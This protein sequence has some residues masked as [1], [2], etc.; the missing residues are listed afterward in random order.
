L[1]RPIQATLV[2]KLKAARDRK[3]RQEGHRIEGRKGYSTTNP[4]LVH[5]AKRLA[6]RS[7]KTGKARPLREI[8]AE[9]AAIGHTTAAGKPFSASQVQRL[10][11]G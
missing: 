6:R 8:A 11:A 4:E 2:G 10:I 5:E 1:D 7:P 9:L 3:S